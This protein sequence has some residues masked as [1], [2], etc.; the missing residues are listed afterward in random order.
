MRVTT[1]V[2]KTPGVDGRIF[3]TEDQLQLLGAT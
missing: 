3:L 1:R 2:A